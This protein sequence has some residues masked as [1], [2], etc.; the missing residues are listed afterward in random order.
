MFLYISLFSSAT[1]EEA[2]VG[3]ANLIVFLPK[4]IISSSLDYVFF[5]LIP[6]IALDFLVERMS[7]ASLTMARLPAM[8]PFLPKGFELS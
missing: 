1:D 6:L 3:G 5:R 2:S 8:M 4:A 7:F